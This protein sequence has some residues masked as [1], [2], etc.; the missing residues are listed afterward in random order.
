[1]QQKKWLG[2]LLLA[3]SFLITTQ[4]QSSEIVINKVAGEKEQLVVDILSLVLSKSDT[5]A[6]V[7]QRSEGLPQSRLVEEIKLGNVDLMWAGVDPTLE[8]ELLPVRIPILKGLLGHR[9]F[10][11]KAENQARFDDITTLDELKQLKAGQGTVWGDTQILKNAGIPVITTLKYSNLFLML[12][13]ERF[14]YFPRAIHEPWSEIEERPELNLAVEKKL[15]LVYPFAMYFFVAKDNQA[16]H[17]KLYQGFEMAIADGSFDE[18]FFSNQLIK[19]ALSK[20]N[21]KNRTVIKIANPAMH[22]D[23]P[24]DRKEFWLDATRL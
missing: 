4:A 21:I 24:I 19:D 17:D 9:I 2:T 22:P 20:T 23:T 12:E 1:M 8:S 7:R 6:T 15:M 14:D 16:L 5:A 10:T 11:I 3:F 13:G 18:L